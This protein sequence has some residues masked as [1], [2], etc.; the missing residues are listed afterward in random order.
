MVAPT[1]YLALPGTARE[2]LSFYHSVF[3]GELSLH[4]YDDFGRSDGP[5]D[6]IAHGELT[7]P[8]SISAAD[9]A[10]GDPVFSS[11]GLLFSLLGV[12]EPP[13]LRAWFDALADGG[14]VVTPL[15]R[16]EWGDHDGVVRD[17]FGID[18]L[19]GFRG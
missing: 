14:E 9:A 15:E 8:V 17:R 10:V 1:P 19:I 3:G 11:T 16:R 7:G 4:T 18:W 5:A 2:A 13:L 6:A 12:E